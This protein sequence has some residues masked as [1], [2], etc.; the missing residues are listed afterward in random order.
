MHHQCNAKP[1][2][3]LYVDHQDAA[4]IIVSNRTRSGIYFSTAANAVIYV[5]GTPHRCF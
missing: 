1:L 5:A 4:H 3:D 2:R